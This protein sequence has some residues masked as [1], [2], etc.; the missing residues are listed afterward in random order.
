MKTQ[1]L[2]VSEFGQLCKEL[3]PSC[4]VFATENQP[5]NNT[6]STLKAT[7][8]YKIVMI[9]L[10]PNCISFKSDTACLCFERVKRVL[11]NLENIGIG[12]IF[13]IVCG[14]KKNSLN[15]VSYT[16]IAD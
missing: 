6:H 12:T 15:D 5:W 13:T 3:K 2:S 7:A 10:N 11:I 9:S 16:L 4:Y 8:R 1:I 14:D